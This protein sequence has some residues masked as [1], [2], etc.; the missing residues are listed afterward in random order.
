MESELQTIMSHLM[1]ALGTEPRSSAE[2]QTI[3][4]AEPSLHVHT[5]CL[6]AHVPKSSLKPDRLIAL[7][8]GCVLICV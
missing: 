1:C 7:G 2:Q 5:V 3:L 4:T 8:P 6:I